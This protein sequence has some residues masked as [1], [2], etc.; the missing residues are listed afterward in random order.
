ML[1]LSICLPELND[2]LLDA[3]ILAAQLG[4]EVT[5][6]QSQCYDKTKECIFDWRIL[7]HTSS[8]CLTRSDAA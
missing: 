1:Y 4:V 2:G 3:I 6:A 8:A 5:L 7:P